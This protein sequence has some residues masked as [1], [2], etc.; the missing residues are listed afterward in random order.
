MSVAV[1]SNPPPLAFFI[2]P[3]CVFMMERLPTIV[4]EGAFDAIRFPTMFSVCILAL[5]HHVAALI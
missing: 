4:A 5:T 1:I 2:N 3:G